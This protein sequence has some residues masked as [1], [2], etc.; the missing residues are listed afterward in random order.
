VITEKSGKKLWE[1]VELAFYYTPHQV[2]FQQKSTITNTS[3]P[4]FLAVL[5]SDKLTEK[6]ENV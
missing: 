6:N 2:V 4:P 1:T 3:I 5:E